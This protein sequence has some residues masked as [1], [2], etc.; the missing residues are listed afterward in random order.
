MGR[1]RGKRQNV[2]TLAEAI[3]VAESLIEYKNSRRDIKSGGNKRKGGG[4]KLTKRCNGSNGGS[5]FER[6]DKEK[7]PTPSSSDKT[8]HRD[9]FLCRGPHWDREC[10]NQQ[11]LNSIIASSGESTGDEAQMGNLCLL[12]SV[13]A[14]VEAMRSDN[15]AKVSTLRRSKRSSLMF[16]EAK[17]N[18]QASRALVDTGATHHFVAKGEVTRLG[19]KYAKE[20]GRLKT[21]KTSPVPILGI[22]RGVPLCL[23]EWKGTVDLTFVNMGDFSLVLGME[24][25]DSVKP[26]TFGRDDTL[27]IGEDKGAW[28]VPI[29]QEDVEPKMLSA[30][31]LVKGM[32][33]GQETFLAALVEEGPQ[34]NEVPQEISGVLKDFEDVMPLELPKKLPPRREVDH[35]IELE[36]GVRPPAMSTYRMAPPELEELRKQLKELLDTGFIRPS[37]APYGASMLFQRKHDG[38]LHMCI[39]YRALNKIAVKNKY[40]IPL[41]ADLFDQLGKAKYFSKINLRSGYWQ[42]RIAEGDEPKTACV[43]QYGSYEFLVMPFG[44]TNAP[45]A[46]CTLI[47]K[48][49]RPFLNDFVVVYL[50]DIVVYSD[51]LQDHMGHLRKVFQALREDE[52]YVKK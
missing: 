12:S 48:I 17:V 35:E 37:K 27:T 46:F 34:G 44:L 8:K 1:A 28:S 2:Q 15:V 31:Q 14:T 11:K 49:L 45:A 43:T 40:P 38:S 30:I 5:K 13:K 7:G 36:P 26:W 18:E 24:F 25:M 29:T 16:V 20:P 52:L 32:M 22:A 21:V 19:L 9:Y 41:V 47:N 42:V 6:K 10:P 3:A 33:K 23:G 50:D 51:K 39:D 4:A